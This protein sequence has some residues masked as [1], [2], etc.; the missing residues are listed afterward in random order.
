M[1]EV[2]NIAVIVGGDTDEA[3]SSFQS[4][5]NVFR[6]IDK[7]VFNPVL[8][9]FQNNHWKVL[10]IVEEELVVQQ[11]LFSLDKFSYFKSDEWVKFDAAFICIHGYPGETGHLQALLDLKKIPYTG[12][13]HSAATVTAS[14]KFSKQ[15]ASQNGILTP[16]FR[17]FSQSDNINDLKGW[18]YPCIVKPNQYGSGI[19]VCKVYDEQAL[20]KALDAALL[21][22]ELAMV[23]EFIDGKELTVA[24]IVQDGECCSISIIEVTRDQPKPVDGVIEYT[25]RQSAN[26]KLADLPAEL[27]HR[28]SQ[29]VVTVSKVFSLRHFFRVDLMLN[30]DNEIFFLEINTIPGMTPKSVFTRQL[31][32]AGIRQKQFYNDVIKSLF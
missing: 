32:L 12:A 11:T 3:R 6:H 26:L 4:G 16:K 20:I 30:G 22:D 15:V 10:Q 23:E 8:L 31:E 18:R 29:M 13:K 27:E 14:K 7:N 21:L 1:S 9:S 24:G 17:V 19:G 28:I 25:N 2:K 5:M